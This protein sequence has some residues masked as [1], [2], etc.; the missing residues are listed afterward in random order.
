[1]T[2]I[3]L[4]TAASGSGI[5]VYVYK[6][7]GFQPAVPCIVEMY[8]GGSLVDM[9]TSDQINSEHGKSNQSLP[10]ITEPASSD[11]SDSESN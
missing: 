1:M 7:S 3:A 5:G 2:S 4:G 10:K 8:Q 11:S 9:G 6:N